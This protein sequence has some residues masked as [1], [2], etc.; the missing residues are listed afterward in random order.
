MSTV[1]RIQFTATIHATAAVV[2]HHITSLESYEQWT[3]AFAEG[4]SFEGAWDTGSKIRFLSPSGDG[5]L[6][7]IAESRRNEFISI[8]HL[9]FISNGTEDTTSDAVRA[10]APAYENYTLV[11]ID[12]GTTMIVDQDVAA[13]WEEHMTQAWPKALDLLKQ[14][15]EATRAT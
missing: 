13:E 5:M 6:S 4:S 1:K 11:P 7:E 12:G 2:W 8:R 3:S 9:G 14:L 15:C 10:W